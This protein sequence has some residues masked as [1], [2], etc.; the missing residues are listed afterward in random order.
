MTASAL[1]HD[2]LAP[3]I[4][5]VVMGISLVAAGNVMPRLRPNLVAGVRTRNTLNDPELWRATHRLLGRTFV[6]AGTV[7]ALVGL[8][9]PAY[10]L[11][12]AVVALISACIVALRRGTRARQ[13]MSAAAF[14][15]VALG[16][17][18]DPLAQQ[19]I[20]WIVAFSSPASVVEKPFAF[21]CV[22]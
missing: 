1:G 22:D 18:R 10:G 17:G 2:A 14:L 13:G 3:R 4:I 16:A 9:L 8:L 11:M 15:C 21:E 5:T 7:T 19:P 20:S 12:T 6:I